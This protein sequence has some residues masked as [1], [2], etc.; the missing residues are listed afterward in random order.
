MPQIFS[1]DAGAA[2][3]RRM[4]AAGLVPVSLEVTQGKPSTLRFS[5]GS[6]SPTTCL[7]CPT[8]PCMT[9]REE[10]VVSASLSEFPADRNSAVCPA[11]AITRTNGGAPSI[12]SAACMLCGVCASRCPV[13]AIRLIPHAI[14]DDTARPA[15]PETDVHAAADT[16]LTAV[17]AVPRSGEFLNES[18]T[19][20]DDLRSRMLAAW[21]RN[22]DRFPDLLARNLLIAA[23][24]GAAMRRK[25]DVFARMDIVLGSPWPDF[26]C[27]EAEFGDEAVLDAPRDLLDDIAVSVGRL[28]RDPH[29]L[30]A[31]V[32][33]DVLPNWRSEYWRI[34]QD[35]RKVVGVKIGTVT[36]LALCLLV[37]QRRKMSDLP[38]HLFHV[39][40]DTPSYREA[41][42]EPLLGRK[43]R[44][45]LAPRPFV[46]V[47]K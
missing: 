28:G 46:D 33:T 21:G 19:V 12:D 25:G 32:I 43:L 18:D 7:R 30:S 16:T 20:V 11:G 39:D 4:L 42:L 41:V 9:F 31:L 40:I 13:G 35:I 26:G 15:F 14:I 5:N 29:S 1:R 44:I 23:G 2:A 8:V 38:S 22:G 17:S 47:A 34:V 6:S 37:W 36:V 10:E 45:D 27:A 24:C 3:P